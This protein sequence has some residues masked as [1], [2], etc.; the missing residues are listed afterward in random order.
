[1]FSLCFDFNVVFAF[2]ILAFPDVC[3]HVFHIPTCSKRFKDRNSNVTLC[4]FSVS[5]NVSDV[6]RFTFLLWSFYLRTCLFQNIRMQSFC[7]TGHVFATVVSFF[8][9]SLRS[10]DSEGTASCACNTGRDNKRGQD[11]NMDDTQ[12]LFSLN[13]ADGCREVKCQRVSQVR[14]QSVQC[15]FP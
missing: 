7:F 5:F 8:P 14:A 3:P 1:M 10:N 2:T 6:F 9:L 4:S 15:H 12:T 13:D 11:Q